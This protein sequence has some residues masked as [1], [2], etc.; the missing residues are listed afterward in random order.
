MRCKRL[1]VL[2]ISP[3]CCLRL[4]A[5]STYYSRGLEEKYCMYASR[6]AGQL[7]RGMSRAWLDFLRKTTS[8]APG[9]QGALK[10]ASR[11]SPKHGS[12]ERQAQ[13]GRLAEYGLSGGSFSLHFLCSM[14]TASFPYLPKHPKFILSR[15]FSILCTLK[16]DL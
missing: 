10:S 6:S 14:P 13:A 3:D 7:A 8:S 5:H 1:L 9:S 2:I 11:K 16:R 4:A 15:T 12:I